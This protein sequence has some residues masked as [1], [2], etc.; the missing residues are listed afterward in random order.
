MDKI[1]ATFSAAFYP[2]HRANLSRYRGQTAEARMF[3]VWQRV[4]RNM[5]HAI[6]EV[7]EEIGAEARPQKRA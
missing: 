1:L 4:G 7:G 3:R 2:F 5:R 6:G